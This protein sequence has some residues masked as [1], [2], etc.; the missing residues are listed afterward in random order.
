[1][2]KTADHKDQTLPRDGVEQQRDRNAEEQKIRA[3][4]ESE[5]ITPAAAAERIRR[6]T[7]D[8]V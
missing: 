5:G 7:Q 6:E 1:M 8:G 4:A 3:L 2:S